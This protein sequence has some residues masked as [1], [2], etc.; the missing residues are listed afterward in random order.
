MI[1]K[2]RE[3]NRASIATLQQLL[4]RPD[5]DAAT[6]QAIGAQIRMLRSGDRGEAEAAYQIDFAYGDNP[7]WIIIH[8]L[9]IEDKGRVAQIDHLLINRLLE[10]WICET[11]C[12]SSGVT[13]NEQG[14]FTTR[15]NGQLKRAPSPIEQNLR[16]LRVMQAVIDSAAIRLPT[17]L[18]FKIRPKLE[19][20][21]LISRGTVTRPA[22]PVRGI[23][24]VINHDQLHA[25]IAR[26]LDAPRLFSLFK[27]VGR[28]TL[29]DLG[30]QVL[31]LHRPHSRRWA[32]QFGFA[33]VS[34]PAVPIARATTLARRRIGPLT[35]AIRPPPEKLPASCASC[36]TP[37]SQGIARYCTATTRFGGTVLCMSCQS[38][39][40]QEAR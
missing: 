30:R 32:A 31:A 40:L 24:S 19:S 33:E 14:E 10:F 13:I 39:G 5:A 4:I 17:R 23:D 28:E 7:D 15:H 35:A 16:H 18:G 12:F 29:H 36:A 8:D 26:A 34:A 37:V 11:K 22:Q 27:L 3:D 20:L 2:H 21:V 9:R 25:T 6:Q 1:L 38:A